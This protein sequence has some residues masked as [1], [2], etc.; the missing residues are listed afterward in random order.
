MEF[1]QQVKEEEKEMKL[2]RIQPKGEANQD[3][4]VQEDPLT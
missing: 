1:L 3:E 4:T 2:G